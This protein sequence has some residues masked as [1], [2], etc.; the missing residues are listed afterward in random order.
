[1]I[2]SYIYIKL[3]Q[4]KICFNLTQT[5]VH[6]EYLLIELFC[7][8]FKADFNSKCFKIGVNTISIILYGK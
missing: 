8:F 2:M 7:Y 6:T 3:G 1:M 5:H 4:N